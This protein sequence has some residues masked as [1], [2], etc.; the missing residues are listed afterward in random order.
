M[1][2]KPKT[3]KLTKNL[4]AALSLYDMVPTVIETIVQYVIVCV[5]VKEDTADG[6][7]VMHGR[8]VK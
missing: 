5:V 6:C 2:N 7:V 3:P 1:Q 8:H 4:A